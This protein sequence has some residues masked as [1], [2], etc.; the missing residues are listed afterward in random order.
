MKS[1]DI[2]SF[3]Q[4]QYCANDLDVISNKIKD[5]ISRTLDSSGIMY[6]IFVRAKDKDSVLDK[7]NRKKNKYDSLKNYYIQDAIGIRIVLY[8]MDD[9]EICINMLSDIFKEN[10]HEVD[11]LDTSTFK[12]ER[13]NYVYDIPKEFSFPYEYKDKGGIDNT[14]EIQIRTVFSEGWHEVEHDIRY[15]HQTDWDGEYEMGRD[16]NA[17][18]AVL[19]LC[20]NNIIGICDNLSYNKYKKHDIEAMIRNRFRIRIKDRHIRNELKEIINRDY[21]VIAKKIFRFDRYMLISTLGKTA[22]ERTL[23]NIVYII[24]Y[25]DI[26]NEDIKSLTDSCVLEKLSLIEKESV[27]NL[28]KE[29]Y[30]SIVAMKY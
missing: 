13:I 11:E 29:N 23:D 17:L 6:R 12:P 25:F 15:K 24:N 8:F 5:V 7:I 1:N 19:E 14:F 20:D 4:N 10:N 18:F 30:K 9:V 3:V 16:L 28:S 21:D 2:L 27:I 26:K 22:I